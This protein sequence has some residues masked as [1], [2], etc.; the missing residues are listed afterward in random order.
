MNQE[1]EDAAFTSEAA[2]IIG[3]VRTEDGF[4]VIKFVDKVVAKEANYEDAKDEIESIL[5]GSKVQEEYYV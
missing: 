3:P 5:F 2:E 1:F 4:H